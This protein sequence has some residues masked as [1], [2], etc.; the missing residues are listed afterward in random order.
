LRVRVLRNEDVSRVIAFIPPGHRHT[1]AALFIG[2][3]VL[4]LQ[5]A[6]LDALIRAYV[7]VALHPIRRAV[8]LVSVKV[9]K[10]IRKEGFTEYQLIESGRSEDEV[11]NEV[12]KLYLGGDEART[13]DS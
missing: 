4:V 7:L 2:D 6:T 11:L 10:G 1:R 9:L 8:E 5:Q 13:S 12:A 3:E